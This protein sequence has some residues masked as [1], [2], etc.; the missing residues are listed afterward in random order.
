MRRR[1]RS[2]IDDPRGVY[3][4]DSRVRFGVLDGS[5]PFANQSLEAVLKHTSSHDRTLS[6]YRRLASIDDI[7]LSYADES[8]ERT[9]RAFDT[10]HLYVTG[11]RDCLCGRKRKRRSRAKSRRT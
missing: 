1:I 4:V 3:F 2:S 8:W 6:L 7:D 9:L 10:C 5:L 11:T